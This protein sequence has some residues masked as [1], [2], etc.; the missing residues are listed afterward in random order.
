MRN[1]TIRPG[2]QYPIC[3][4]IP[5]GKYCVTDTLL[6]PD[7]DVCISI[8]NLTKSFQEGTL[9]YNTQAHTFEFPISSMESNS[10]P[11]GY[12]QECLI[13]VKLATINNE[14]LIY[15]YNGPDIFVLEQNKGN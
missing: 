14:Q 9:N 11:K 4:T 7:G 1:I 2:D 12:K 8:G 6:N 10:M 5:L 15:S 3:F 13:K